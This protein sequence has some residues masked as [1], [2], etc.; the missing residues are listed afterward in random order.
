MYV[1]IYI[2]KY[3]YIYIY[4]YISFEIISLEIERWTSCIFG[5][6]Q[7]SKIRPSSSIGNVIAYRA[8]RQPCLVLAKEVRQV[9]F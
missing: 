5:P 2:Y 3:K 8:Y 1:Y 4:M 6:D 9:D 7:R